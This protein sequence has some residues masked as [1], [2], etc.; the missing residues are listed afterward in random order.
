MKNL[1]YVLALFVVAS[2]ATT[3]TSKVEITPAGNWDYTIT[4]TP[5]GNF[6]GVMTVTKT[7]NQFAATLNA[8]GSDLPIEKFMWDKATNK[9]TGEFYYSGTPVMFDGLMNGDEITGGMSAGGM[10]FPFKA[11]R[12]K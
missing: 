11:V 7:E 6:A 3:K 2:C 1:F 5:E 8:N 12:K 10:N 9:L 4:G